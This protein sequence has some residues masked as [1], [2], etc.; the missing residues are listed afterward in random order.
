MAACGCRQVPWASAIHPLPALRWLVS[1]GEPHAIAS[2]RDDGARQLIT[3]PMQQ[4]LHQCY[5]SSRRNVRQ[6]DDPRV[7]GVEPVD[8]CP[9][10]TVDRD[11]DPALGGGEL[12][13][14]CIA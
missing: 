11:K 14:R 12:Q 2:Y 6:S 1:A 10:V 5:A 7:A 9:K 3:M 4:V 8:Q 13:Q